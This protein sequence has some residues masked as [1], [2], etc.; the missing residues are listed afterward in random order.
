[1]ALPELLKNLVY[2]RVNSP[3]LNRIIGKFNLHHIWD[4]VLLNTPSL[5]IKGHVQA[6]GHAQST[7]PNTSKPLNNPTPPCNFSQVLWNMLRE[8]PCLSMCIELLKH[9]QGTELHFSLRHDEVQL[10][11][12]ENSLTTTNYCFRESTICFTHKNIQCQ[13]TSDTL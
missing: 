3:A 5:K 4:R 12:D 7:Q 10:W 13:P 2:I 11:L 8:H 9:I 1:M 6:V